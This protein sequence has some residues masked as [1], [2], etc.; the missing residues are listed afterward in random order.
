VNNHDP[1]HLGIEFDA[2]YRGS[3]GWDHRDKGPDVR[4]IR[5]SKLTATPLP[6]ILA[7][8]NDF[9]TGPN[10]TG[11]AMRCL[12]VHQRRQTLVPQPVASP[13]GQAI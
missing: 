6:R 7:S 5:I 2:D 10:S 11:A 8:T 13:A 4:R 1:K 12:I 3:Y 9:T